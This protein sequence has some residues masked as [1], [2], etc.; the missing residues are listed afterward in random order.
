MSRCHQ[1]REGIKVESL[2]ARLRGAGMKL[3]PQ[4]EQLLDVLLHHP[5]PISAD[6]IFK[7]IKKSG[8]DLVTIYRCL[9][10]FEE[11]GLVSRSEFGDGVAGAERHDRAAS[12]AYRAVGSPRRTRDPSSSSAPTAARRPPRDSD[13]AL[14]WDRRRTRRGQ[15]AALDAAA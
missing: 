13:R 2:H 5:K 3:T 8:T 14:A 15:A 4:R 9:K 12:D 1:E 6:E 11:G 7:K 10:K